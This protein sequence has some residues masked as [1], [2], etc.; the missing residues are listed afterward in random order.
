M[1]S[2]HTA[3]QRCDQISA[4]NEEL[5]ILERAKILSLSPD[6]KHAL[7]SYHSELLKTFKQS[8]DIDTSRSDK[9]LSLGMKLASLFGA[10]AFAA[11]VFFLFYQY[12]GYISTSAQTVLLVVSPLVALGLTALLYEKEQSGY[13]AKIGGLITLCCFV[14][15]LSMLGQIFNLPSSPTAFVLWSIF[16]LV[17]AY[18]LSSRI[19]LTLSILLFA[20]FLSARVG[21]WFGVYWVSF[22][23]RPET[24]LMPALII[25]VAGHF[26]QLHHENF[27]AIYRI[28]GAILF[29]MPVLVL[30]HWSY[31]SFFDLPRDLL[32]GLYQIVGFTVSAAL[33][34]YGIA[35]RWGDTINTGTVFFVIFL[36]TKFFDWWWDWFPKYLFF[37]VIALTSI[38]MLLVFKRLRNSAKSDTKGV[39]H[40]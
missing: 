26:K 17:L 24:F 36:Y 5:A 21:T 20:G 15:N 33:V 18:K 39:Q 8:F 12:W 9:Q 1:D 31:G 38:L 30:S 25:F 10:L 37:L 6:T 3:Q 35:K 23:E 34:W 27:A 4:F 11:S 7:D 16:A 22:G 32:E 29:L 19:L 40:V 28:F 2:K 13:F 14:L